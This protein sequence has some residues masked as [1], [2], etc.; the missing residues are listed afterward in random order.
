[1]SGNWQAVFDFFD[2]DMQPVIWEKGGQ[3][4]I[5]REHRFA[6]QAGEVRKA[7]FLARAVMVL[8]SQS[9]TTAGTLR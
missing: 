7:T 6:G 9:M 5:G 4:H 3:S 8:L 1:M 2:V